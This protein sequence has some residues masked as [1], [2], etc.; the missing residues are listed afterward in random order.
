M[1]DRL[2]SSHI[3]GNV[4]LSANSPAPLDELVGTKLIAFDT[5]PRKIFARRMSN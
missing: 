2:T 4:G 3:E 1:T 5:N